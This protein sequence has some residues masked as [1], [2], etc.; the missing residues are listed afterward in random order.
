MGVPIKA[1]K[2]SRYQG[3]CSKC[4]RPDLK[5]TGKAGICSRC[6]WRA[7]NG[8]D[9]VETEIIK[10]SVATKPAKVK[11]AQSP[12]TEAFWEA[13]EVLK[14]NPVQLFDEVWMQ[15]RA[16]WIKELTDAT[17]P[18]KRLHLAADMLNNMNRLTA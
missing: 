10:T 13:F 15:T 17:D 3:T 6:Y 11:A 18:G 4:H 14:I 8:K 5:L 9:P 1:N 7:K 12:R 2:T 16:K